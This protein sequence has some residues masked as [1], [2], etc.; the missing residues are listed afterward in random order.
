MARELHAHIAE[1]PDALTAPSPRCPGSLPRLL[2]TLEAAGH[3]NAVT[4]LD[5]PLCGRTPRKVSRPTPRG[6]ACGW[7][8]ARTEFR[9]CSRCGENSHIVTRS[10]D[11]GAVCR[12]CYQN[13]RR[14]T[15]PCADCGRHG[16][17]RLRRRKNSLVALCRRCAGYP[18]REC[19]R[20]GT[21]RPVQANSPDGPL[22]SRCYTAPA[23]LCGK[24]GQ[25]AQLAKRGKN[26]E[27]GVCHR[28][29]TFEGGMHHLRAL[30]R[31][32]AQQQSRRSLPLRP[33]PPP[34]YAP[35][36]R[37]WPQQEG[38]RHHMAGRP[39]LLALLQQAS[40]QPGALCPL[41][42]HPHTGRSQRRGPWNLRTLLRHRHRLHLPPMRF[43]GGH[44]HGRM[45]HTL[46]CRRPSP[47]AHRR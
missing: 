43:V 23:K 8:V 20:C 41:R 1:H 17:Y 39:P 19:V 4:Q 29:Y 31:R 26:G 2:Q 3:G 46:C 13:E 36:R 10:E 18:D 32:R 21:V 27:P 12:S 40:T 16:A 22:C 11:E 34:A 14:F 25:L 35:M 37:L 7:C 28:C 9:P 45:L 15:G 33:M 24:C 42:C 47:R 6:R 44:Q 38:H 5:C 30:P